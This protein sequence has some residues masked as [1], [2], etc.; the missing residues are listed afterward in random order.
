V[1]TVAS[2]LPNARCIYL[3]GQDHNFTFSPV[4]QDVIDALKACDQGDPYYLWS[5]RGTTKTMIT[6]WQE[7]M[8]KA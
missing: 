7:R 6:E 8:K 5:G 2:A 3:R 1:A 4:S